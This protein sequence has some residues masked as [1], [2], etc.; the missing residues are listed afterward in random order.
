MVTSEPKHVF[1]LDLSHQHLS[2]MYAF[3]KIK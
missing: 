3:Q 2:N 1:F